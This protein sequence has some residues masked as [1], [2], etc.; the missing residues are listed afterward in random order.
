MHSA[1]TQNHA[2]RPVRPIAQ[3]MLASVSHM[4]SRTEME[5]VPIIIRLNLELGFSMARSIRVRGFLCSRSASILTRAV[6]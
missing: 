6:S 3:T 2:L 1:S 5:T 4:K